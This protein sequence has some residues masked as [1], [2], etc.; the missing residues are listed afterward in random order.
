MT[1]CA[2]SG[3][4]ENNW[5][6]Q[7]DHQ[8]I[9]HRAMDRLWTFSTSFHRESNGELPASYCP[10]IFT[11][12]VSLQLFLFV[13]SCS[14]G[15]AGISQPNLSITTTSFNWHVAVEPVDS[16]LMVPC[17]PMQTCCPALVGSGDDGHGWF[18][19]G[20]SHGAKESLQVVTGYD[21][22]IQLLISIFWINHN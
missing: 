13:Y 21:R 6:L 9:H 7:T 17:C 18:L 14:H 19:Q 10:H 20:H 16:V 1:W 22:F 2:R 8:W 4:V 3:N 15:T 12:H 11:N 5:P